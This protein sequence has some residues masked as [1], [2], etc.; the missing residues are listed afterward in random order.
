VRRLAELTV[1]LAITLAPALAAGEPFVSLF[2]GAAFT[3]DADVDTTLNLDSLAL[4]DGT[5]RNVRFDTA[6]FFGAKGG[7]FFEP[8]IL[9]GH[10]GLE[11]EV[12][13]FELRVGEQTVRFTGTSLGQPIDTETPIQKVD[14]DVTTIG[15]H[16][17]YRLPLAESPEFPRGRVH[18]YLGLGL[19][20]WIASFATTT[21]PLDVNRHVSD[22]DLEPALQALAGVKLFVTGHLAV[23][24]EYKF[25]QS[26]RLSFTSR[27]SGTRGGAPVREV[28][29]DR[30]DLT[31]HVVVGGIAFHW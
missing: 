19:D 28:A 1:V 18:P 5:L 22:D 29:V 16:A 24:A 9:G 12:A 17:L 15:L 10:V 31:S 13:H 11:L 30:A 4:L 14:V 21:S 26:A 3:Q 20:L 8:L 25:L 6:P 7:Y 23:F 27:A 2:A